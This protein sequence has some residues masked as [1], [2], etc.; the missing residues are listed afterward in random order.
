M[1]EPSTPNDSQSI[2]ADNSEVG[3]LDILIVLAKY[4]LLIFGL[5]IIVAVIAAVISLQMTPI[6]T[7][8]T[9]ILPPQQS[10]S[11]A[12]AMLAQLG[13]IAGAIGGAAKGANDLYVAMLRSRTVA[14]SLIERFDLMKSGNAK[15][16]SEVRRKLAGVTNISSG[17]DGIITIEIDDDNPKRAADLAN[18]YVD[19]LLKLTQVL[20]VTESS[21]RRLFFERQLSQAK[22]S[23]AKAE[24][25][26]RQALERGGLM[27][28]DDQGRAMVET[29]A[30]L[31]AQITVK[32]VQIGAMRTFAADRN[33][34]LLLVQRELE[35]LRRELGKVEGVGAAKGAASSVGVQGLDSLRLL[36]DVKYHEVIFDLLAKQYELAK[37]DEAKESAVVQVMDEAIAPD[38]KSKPIRRQIVLL[39]A[40]VALFFGILIAFI[41]EALA[42]VKNDPQQLVRVQALKRYSAWR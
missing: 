21:Q 31:R 28:V 12:A 39:S 27:K 5:P 15:Y 8:V 23:L 9:K 4:K 38:F 30:R 34:D 40:L 17:R 42:K 6:Y 37:I 26:A 18:A 13:G 14:D 1:T 10:Q 11:T 25:S 33:P 19:E 24:I 35:L 22:D 29:S 3:L 32:E 7:A 2:E 36:R 41:L 16:P 20:A